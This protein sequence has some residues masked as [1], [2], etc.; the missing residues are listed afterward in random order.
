MFLVSIVGN[1]CLMFY[2]YY[3]KSISV[4]E[5]IGI[6]VFAISNLVI[7]ILS[8]SWYFVFRIQKARKKNKEQ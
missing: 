2:V 8:V 5:Q 7:L 1:V 6:L 3:T 4:L